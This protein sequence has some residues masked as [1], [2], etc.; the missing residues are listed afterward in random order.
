MVVHYFSRLAIQS[1]FFGRMPGPPS[2]QVNMESPLLDAHFTLSQGAVMSSPVAR[3]AVV[4]ICIGCVDFTR[5]CGRQLH[6]SRTRLVPGVR[7]RS[8]AVH[9]TYT[10]GLPSPATSFGRGQQFSALISCTSS[11]LSSLSALPRR[12][13]PR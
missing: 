2:V 13:R 3:P 8:V 5:G 11:S 6:A 9:R 12:K 4:R 10:G 7:D 1:Q